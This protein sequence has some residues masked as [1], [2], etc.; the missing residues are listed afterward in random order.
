MR[1]SKPASH[2]TENLFFLK[3]FSVEKCFLVGS[4]VKKRGISNGKN[5][6]TIF[7]GVR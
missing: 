3:L 1:F 7:W 4:G 6:L 2:R 5:D